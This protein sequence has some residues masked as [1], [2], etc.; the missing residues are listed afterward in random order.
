MVPKRKIKVL[1]T[2]Y[3][4]WGREPNSLE[5]PSKQGLQGLVSHSQ[6]SWEDFPGPTKLYSRKPAKTSLRLE[7]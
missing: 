1:S 6:T 3:S 5:G 4:G 2:V 7:R